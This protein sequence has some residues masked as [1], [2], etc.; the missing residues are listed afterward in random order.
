MFQIKWAPVLTAGQLAAASNPQ[1]ANQPEALPWVLYDTQA[2]T[3]AATTTQTYFQNVSADKTL[4]NMESAGQLPDPQYFIMHYITCDILAIPSV[5]NT[6]TIVGAYDDIDRFLKQGRATFT[7][8]MSNKFYGPFPLTL[9][10]STGGATG[11]GWGTSAA[12]N[13]FQVANNGVPGSGG[14]PVL[15]AQVIPPKVGFSIKVELAAAV[16]LN[17][18]P[19][20][21]RIGM[22]GVLYRRVL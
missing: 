8:Q 15:G 11:M 21:V 3:T 17:V 4:C 18:S 13:N 12:S 9:C 1:S 7:F 14:F 10:H 2:F 6:A 19:L 22:A 5:S 20:N 16:T